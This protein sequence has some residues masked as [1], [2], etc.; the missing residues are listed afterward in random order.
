MDIKATSINPATGKQYGINPNSG[1]WDDNYFEGQYGAQ[2]R[3]Y[4]EN[5]QNSD[6]IYQAQ[7]Y[8]DFQKTANAPV[9][10]NLQTQQPGLQD[11]YTQLVNSIKGNQQLDTNRQTRATNNELGQRGI[12][13]TSGVYQQQMVDSLTPI[14]TQYAGLTANANAGSIADTQA[15]ALHIAQLQAGNPENAYASGVQGASTAQGYQNLQNQA[16]SITA[17]NALAAAQAQA[18]QSQV[19]YNQSY[20][21]YWNAFANSINGA[22]NSSIASLAKQ[23]GG[24]Q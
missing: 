7:K 1:I 6:P 2:N 22:N 23:L 15:L 12:L 11:K 16:S 17:Q 18:A 3:Q 21:N 9:V 5:K 14:D 8:L 10:A 19:P 24:Y 4:A 20:G 13:P